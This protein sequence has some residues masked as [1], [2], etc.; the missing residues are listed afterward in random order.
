VRPNRIAILIVG[1]VLSLAGSFAFGYFLERLDNT[2]RGT[3]GVMKLV[4]AMPLVAVPY[5]H[6]PAEISKKSRFKWQLWA[7][8]GLL[9]VACPVLIHFFYM[10]LDVLIYVAQRKLGLL[11]L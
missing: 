6:T 4:G 11:L 8:I 9:V 7:A 1:I 3:Q 10:P 2:V 5:I